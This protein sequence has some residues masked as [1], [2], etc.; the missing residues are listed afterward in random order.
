MPASTAYAITPESSCHPSA[1]RTYERSACSGAKS[2]NE[3]MIHAPQQA[4][5]RP[6]STAC[7]VKKTTRLP[8]DQENRPLRYQTPAP[9]AAAGSTL[10][11]LVN[12]ASASGTR[13][14]TLTSSAYTRVNGTHA[15]R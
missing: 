5:Y 13:P 10:H 4:A 12:T 1:S 6:A 2:L 7:V 11:T 9:R 3:P 15:A 8:P 14:C